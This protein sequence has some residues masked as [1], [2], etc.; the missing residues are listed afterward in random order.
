MT[1]PVK[2]LSRITLPINAVR[3]KWGGRGVH[4]ARD[5]ENAL[6]EIKHHLYL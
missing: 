4:L 6:L 5:W 2:A 1:H 3:R